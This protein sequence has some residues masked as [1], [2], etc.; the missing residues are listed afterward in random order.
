MATYDN[1]AWLLKNIR[2][3]F[4]A[5]DDTGLCET[6]MAGENF[7]KIFQCRA[8]E[9][10]KRFKEGTLSQPST[11][12]GRESGT[13]DEDDREIVTQFD[14]Y[15]DMEDSDE[16]DL[17]GSYIRDEEFIFKKNRPNT[18]QRLDK[19]EQ[20]MK[21][22]AKIKVIKWEDTSTQLTAEEIDEAFAKLEVKKLHKQKSLLAEQLEKCPELPHRQYLEYAKFDGTA[23]MKTPTKTFKIFMTTLP[24]KHQNYPLIVCVIANSKIKDLIGFICYKYSIEH[25]E[26]TL[27]SVH[28]YGLC[29]AED[30]GEVDWAFPCLDA[31]EPC[32]KFGFACLGLVDLKTKIALSQVTT[33][34][35]DIELPFHIGPPFHFF[36]KPSDSGQSHINTSKHSGGEGE[37]SEIFRKALDE[38]VKRF[39]QSGIIADAPQEKIFRVNLLHKMRANTP[40]QLGISLDTIE[41]VPFVAQKHAFWSRP[42]YFRHNINLIA[43]CQILEEKA[44]RTTFRIVY[45]PSHDTAMNERSSSGNTNFFHANTTYKLHDFETDH[46]TAK[47]IVEKVNT[48]LDLRNSPCR[49]EYKTAKEKKLQTRRSFHTKH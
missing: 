4:I 42:K 10:K 39:S 37:A 22:A 8:L 21:K 6:V 18:A 27:G 24:E 15:P 32:S 3:A 31:N 29:L 9:D 43:W 25:P 34:I 38:D 33:P 36:Q 1:K 45:S 46:D 20:A 16:D 30:D 35:P 14:P 23:Q 49:R 41:I 13:D 17:C 19:K 47:T 5:T 26:I 12:R 28:D 7:S 2:D 40:V 44:S 48:I 11:S